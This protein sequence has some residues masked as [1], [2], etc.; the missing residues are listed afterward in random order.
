MIDIDKLN[1]MDK[2]KTLLPDPAPEVVGELIDEVRRL[3]KAMNAAI[4]VFDDRERYVMLGPRSALE[5]AAILRDA[6]NGIQH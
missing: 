3:R 2:C 6:L 5:G 4:E 1:K